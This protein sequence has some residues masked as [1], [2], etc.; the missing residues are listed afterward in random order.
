MEV[1]KESRG[2]IDGAHSRCG[3]ARAVGTKPTVY[4]FFLALDTIYLLLLYK[5]HFELFKNYII[6]TLLIVLI[7]N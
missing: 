2:S 7:N 4:V 3:L 1:G 6:Q 5:L